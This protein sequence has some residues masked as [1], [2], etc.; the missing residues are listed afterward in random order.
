M[1]SYARILEGFPTQSNL[2]PQAVVRNP[3]KSIVN[4]FCSQPMFNMMIHPPG[5]LL[6]NHRFSQNPFLI[7]LS[8]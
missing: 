4:S 3:V 8:N 5:T 1:A 7:E 2:K 6:N